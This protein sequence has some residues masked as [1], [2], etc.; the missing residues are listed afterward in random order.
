[1]RIVRGRNINDLWMG[2]WMT[3]ALL[4]I[5]KTINYLEKLSSFF[6]VQETKRTDDVLEVRGSPILSHFSFSPTGS[7]VLY[8]CVSEEKT[9]ICG[10]NL[11][12]INIILC[13]KLGNRS[14]ASILLPTPTPTQFKINI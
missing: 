9:V 3:G 4:C 7:Y 5:I 12:I 2:V 14:S 6:S 8:F 10:K 11:S 13:K 1:M